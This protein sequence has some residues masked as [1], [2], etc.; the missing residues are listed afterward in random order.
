[1]GVNQ[2]GEECHTGEIEA[3]VVRWQLVPRLDV[4]DPFPLNEHSLAL[5][6]RA[7]KPIDDGRPYQRQTAVVSHPSPL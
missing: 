2:P 1:M 4:D 3:R 6:C 7:T 5:A